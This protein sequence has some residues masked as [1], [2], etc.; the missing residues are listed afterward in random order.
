MIM[1]AMELGIWVIVFLA[2]FYIA[3]LMQEK[4][5]PY[6]LLNNELTTKD[7]PA[8][9]VSFAGYLIATTIIF[10]GAVLGPTYGLKTDIIVVT[11]YTIIGVVLLHVGRWINALL[12]QR[13]FKITRE[14]LEDRNV[15]SGAVEAGNY[16]ASGMIIAGALNGEG[17]GIQSAVAFFLIGQFCLQLFGLLYEWLVPFDIRGEIENDNVAAGISYGGSMVAI[18]I[19]LMHGAS[20][21]FWSWTQNLIQFAMSAVIIIPLLLMMRFVFERTLLP[22]ARLN[23]EIQRD[24]N[25]GAAML[26]ITAAIALSSVV[27]VLF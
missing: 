2:I 1:M 27:F 18:G 10:I 24:R 20:G 22:G 19:M 21:P 4:A 8:M 7:N 16:I 14:I 17:G 5:S 23:D 25:I 12:L 6:R 11:G 3:K 26:E 15:G 13:K 9:A